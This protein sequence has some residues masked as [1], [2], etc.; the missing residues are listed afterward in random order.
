MVLLSS[1]LFH[2]S[3]SSS[4]SS[5]DAPREGIAPANDEPKQKGRGFDCGAEQDAK[6]GGGGG[7]GGGSGGGHRRRGSRRVL[8]L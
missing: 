4:S 5:T 2:S 1:Y 8:L 7:G 6:P 3:S